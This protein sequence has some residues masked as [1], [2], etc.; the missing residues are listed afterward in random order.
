[1]GKE[2][3]AAE[4]RGH[5]RERGKASQHACAGRRIG[6]CRTGKIVP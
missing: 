6:I 2:S 5:H 4:S 1:M 3:M